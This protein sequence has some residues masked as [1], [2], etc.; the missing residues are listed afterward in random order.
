M[1]V[2]RASLKEQLV[3]AWTL[4]RGE[5]VAP[6]GARSP[7][8][9]GNN[10]AGQYIFTEDGH[11]SFQAV[12]EFGKF[13]SDNRMK[14]TPEEN[15]AAVRGSIAYYGTYTVDEADRTILVH[16]ERSSFPNHNGTDGKRV[17]TTLSNDEMGYV[18]PGPRGGGAIHCTYKRLARTSR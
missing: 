1:S 9:T 3:G 6:D 4:V 14:T 7:L 8:V 16:I 11:F 10:L 5:V 12:A 18:N 13:L 2:Q 17:I 15:Q